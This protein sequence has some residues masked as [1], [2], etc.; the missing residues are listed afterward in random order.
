MRRK[1]ATVVV[2]VMVVACEGNLG[3]QGAPGPAGPKGD[4]GTQG[5]PG[6]QGDPGVKGDEGPQGAGPASFCGLAAESNGD[7]GGYVGAGALCVDECG[8]ATAHMCTA[9]QMVLAAQAGDLPSN[10]EMFYA[11][12]MTAPHNDGSDMRDCAGWTNGANGVRGPVWDTNGGSE[13]TRG[14]CNVSHPIACCSE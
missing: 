10:R 7:L 14:D 2:G 6:T 9:Q 1:W 3:Q 4:P 8:S 13:P 12:G 5:E 11:S